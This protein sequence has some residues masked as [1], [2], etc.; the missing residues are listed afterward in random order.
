M[1]SRL[2]GKHEKPV[3]PL[4]FDLIT[5]LQKQTVGPI[6][7]S[8]ADLKVSSM[9]LM[10]FLF[11]FQDVWV[12]LTERASDLPVLWQCHAGDDGYQ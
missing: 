2:Y 10:L 9:V 12:L 4:Q 5:V 11:C 8:A 1:L 7:Q 3:F 6:L